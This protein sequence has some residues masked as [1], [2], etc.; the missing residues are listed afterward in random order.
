[1]TNAA[2]LVAPTFGREPIIGTN[3]IAISVPAGKEPPFCLDIA[4]S[5]RAYG[6]VD[7]REREGRN[8][9]LEW[10]TDYEG[11]LTIDPKEVLGKKGYSKR[12]GE[13]GTMLPLGGFGDETAG[14]KGYGLAVMV[15]ILT[16]L[17]AGSAW[18]I[19]CG[20]GMEAVVSNISHL[21][22]AI[23]IESFRPLDEFKKD[24]DS[25]LGELKNSEKAY[26]YRRNIDVM[27]KGFNLS[28]LETD[29]KFERIYAAGEKG[30]E[31]E[32]EQMENGIKLGL[33][34]V[35]ELESINKQ[36][37]MGYKF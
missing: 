32:K 33:Y 11:K 17:L 15:D 26:H 5:V 35:K 28:I 16:G 36:Y 34:I 3:P 7:I 18:G 24:M 4:T 27:E 12:G 25:M 29:E 10:A 22:G 2:P 13:R 19:H 23:N 6:R 21:V 30:L 20:L 1:M 9:P 31:L 14:Y 37:E 8:I